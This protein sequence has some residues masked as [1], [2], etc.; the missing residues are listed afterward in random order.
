MRGSATQSCVSVVL[1]VEH[2]G[3]GAASL[4]SKARH[5]RFRESEALRYVFEQVVERCIVAGLVGGI[6]FAVEASVV[7]AD[8]SRQTYMDRD[9][10][11]N[12]PRP[13]GSSRPVKEYLAALDAGSEPAKRISLTDPQARWTAALDAP[14]FFAYSDNVLADVKAGIIM[15]VEATPTYRPQE[16]DSTKTMIDRVEAR[17]EIKPEH[18]DGDTTYGTEDP[19]LCS[20]GGAR[21]RALLI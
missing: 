20:R 12:W 16:V 6:G 21:A 13:P 10:D 9:D 8:A 15:D 2:R 7:R 17:F 14:A 18:L 19:S 11:D 5:G 4:D 3:R 1:P